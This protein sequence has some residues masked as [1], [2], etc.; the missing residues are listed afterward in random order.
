M[1]TAVV[2]ATLGTGAPA[3]VTSTNVPSADALVRSA[4]ATRNYG[5]AGALSISGS[6]STN[7]LGVQNGLF[8]TLMRFSLSSAISNFNGAFGAGNWTLVSATLRLTEVAA[9]NN[10]IYNRGIG[11]FQINWMTNDLWIE[12]TGNPSSP[13]M[14]GVVWND[15]PSLTSTG[16]TVSLGIFTNAGQNL[17][18]AF[19]L[20]L[21]DFGFHNALLGG[22]NVNFY[23]TTTDP[24]IGFTFNSRSFGTVSARPMLELTA[25]PEPC[26]VALLGLGG[27]A[28]LIRGF[29]RPARRS[30]R[31]GH[32]ARAT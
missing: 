2:L 7:R 29:W 10:D 12:G 4:D 14:D 30:E 6:A 22:G 24:G 11:S 28:F 25:V 15:L 17:Q 19:A 31:I 1:V 3:A 27:V 23:L 18:Q 21:D 13:T 16:S 8:D 26:S 5:G 32:V 20:P 9:P